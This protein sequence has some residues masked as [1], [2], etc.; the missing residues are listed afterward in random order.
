MVSKNTIAG[1][2]TFAEPRTASSRAQAVVA[3]SIRLME[4]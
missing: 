1:S 4:N 2:L 3:I